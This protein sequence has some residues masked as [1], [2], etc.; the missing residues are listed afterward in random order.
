MTAEQFNKLQDELIEAEKAMSETKGKD[1]TVGD[2]DRLNNFKAVGQLVCCGNCHKPVGTRAVFG[3]YYLKH[4]LAILAW[5]KTNRV[6][7][8]GLFGRFLDMRV[9]STLGLAIHKEEQA[10]KVIKG[11]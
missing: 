9:Y 11:E 4:L 5:I 10:L 1:Y 8:E 3:V 6:E 7:S 2:P